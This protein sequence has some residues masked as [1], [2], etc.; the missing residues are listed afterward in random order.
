MPTFTASYTN[1]RGKPPAINVDAAD[2][3]QAKR[4]P[5]PARHPRHEIKVE[6]ES[7]DCGRKSCW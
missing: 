3:I 1:S 6:N 7:I 2:A 4:K 5:A